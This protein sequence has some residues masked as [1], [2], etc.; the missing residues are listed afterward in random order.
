VYLRVDDKA[1]VQLKRQQGQLA[2][3]KELMSCGGGMAGSLNALHQEQR[4]AVM[5]LYHETARLKVPAVQ[6]Y[7]K[8]LLEND[9]KML[10]FGHHMVLLDGVEK[11]V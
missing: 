5:G 4:Q 6:G 9:V 11:A 10:V 1:A 7:I 3:I 2:E 8:D